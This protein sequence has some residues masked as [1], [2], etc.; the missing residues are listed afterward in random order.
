MGG[1]LAEQL[2]RVVGREGVEITFW[3]HKVKGLSESDVG[4]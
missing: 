4:E 3:E 1:G 2:E